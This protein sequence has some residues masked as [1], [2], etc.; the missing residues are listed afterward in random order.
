MMCFSQVFDEADM[1]LA[2]YKTPSNTGDNSFIPLN[3]T[4]DFEIQ[5]EVS[6]VEVC[7]P[8]SGAIA[9]IS[10]NDCSSSMMRAAT[11]NGV[12]GTDSTASLNIMTSTSGAGSSSPS[13]ASSASRGSALGQTCDFADMVPGDYV[14]SACSISIVAVRTGRYGYTP[15]GKA[16]VADSSKRNDCSSGGGACLPLGNLLIVQKSNQIDP[17]PVNT[18]G[19]I[20]FTFQSLVHLKSI[21]VVDVESTSTVTFTVS[22]VC[23]FLF[24]FA[25]HDN[26]NPP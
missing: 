3:A 5:D 24:Y 15:D 25:A 10:F 11:S 2:M 19:C 22:Q 20:H 8:S 21:G 6:K 1:I 9:S 12:V 14:N 17:E 7:L 18:G 16:R 26:P 13:R 23:D 4:D